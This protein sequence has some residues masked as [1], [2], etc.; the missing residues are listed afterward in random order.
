MLMGKDGEEMEGVTWEELLEKENLLFE[1]MFVQNKE[2]SELYRKFLLGALEMDDTLLQSALE[3]GAGSLLERFHPEEN[4]F[5]IQAFQDDLLRLFRSRFGENREALYAY[6]LR[7]V[8]WCAQYD[9]DDSSKWIARSPYYETYLDKLKAYWWVQTYRAGLGSLRPEWVEVL[10]PVAR[11]IADFRSE[12]EIIWA[13]NDMSKAEKQLR[14]AN[15][16]AE[17]QKQIGEFLLQK[18]L[19]IDLA[20]PAGFSHKAIR[21]D[22]LK[23]KE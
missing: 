2:E 9:L 5:G 4:A 20:S 14:V 13:R 15:L 23:K 18:G 3:E 7:Y 6:L 16:Y 22:L 21:P 17:Y 12:Q 10:E 11:W 8:R 1:E 19:D